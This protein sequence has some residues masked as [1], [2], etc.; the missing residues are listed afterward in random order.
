ML[1]FFRGSSSLDRNFFFFRFQSSHESRSRS[2]RLMTDRKLMSE[3]PFFLFCHSIVHTTRAPAKADVSYQLK[4]IKMKNRH[5]FSR[6]RTVLESHTHFPGLNNGSMTS[7]N[8]PKISSKNTTI[9]FIF[10]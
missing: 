10:Q 6:V 5:S 1:V 7:P 8:G 9:S 4:I 2:T 3:K